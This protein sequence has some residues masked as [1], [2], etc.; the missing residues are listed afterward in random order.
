MRSVDPIDEHAFESKLTKEPSGGCWNA[1]GSRETS[2][3]T[4]NPHQTPH[5]K[6]STNGPHTLKIQGSPPWAFH[7]S[8]PFQRADHRARA[9]QS[10]G[11]QLRTTSSPG[12]SEEQRG[13]STIRARAPW[14]H[15]QTSNPLPAPKGHRRIIGLCP[16]PWNHLQTL[17]SPPVPKDHHRLLGFAP[18]TEGTSTC[19]GITLCPEGQKTTR[20][21]A[22]DPVETSAGVRITLCPEGQETTLPHASDSVEAQP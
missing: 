16:A 1:R 10:R 15:R 12:S 20:P 2:S 13:D 22:S 7:P 4:V 6:N 11:T 17:E 18:G 19:L 9:A 3:R 14:N 5:G 21:H 8:S